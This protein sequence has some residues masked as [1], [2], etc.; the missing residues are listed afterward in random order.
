MTT[1]LELRHEIDALKTEVS[2]LKEFVKM[3]YN[4]MTDE[5]EEYDAS[6][7]AGGAEVGRFNT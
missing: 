7:Y 1:E 3:L 5:E 6:N 4:M 2:G